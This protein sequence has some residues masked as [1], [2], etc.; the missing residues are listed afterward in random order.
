[1]PGGRGADCRCTNSKLPCIERGVPNRIS[2]PQTRAQRGK[3]G[4]R[5]HEKANLLM[6]AKPRATWPARAFSTPRLWNAHAALG[7][8]RIASVRRW[9]SAR[10][11]SSAGSISSS[12]AESGESNAS[13]GTAFAPPAPRAPANGRQHGR[14]GGRQN[15]PRR[16]CLCCLRLRGLARR[17]S[18]RRGSGHQRGIVRPFACEGEGR[19]R[20]AANGTARPGTPRTPP[21]LAP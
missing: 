13:S 11:T 8:A 16:A 20:R 5:S 3:H 12:D 2:V 18:G 19:A 7:S 9:S 17:K 10:S 15:S 21:L 4:G 1:M 6:S 14:S